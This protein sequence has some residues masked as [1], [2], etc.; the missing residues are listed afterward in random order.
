[1]IRYCSTSG[2]RV[3][4]NECPALPQRNRQA[5][6]AVQM[7]V[8]IWTNCTLFLFRS[9]LRKKYATQIQTE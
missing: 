4:V 3:L 6:D 5:G 8:I 7:R 9:I 1:M 2:Q